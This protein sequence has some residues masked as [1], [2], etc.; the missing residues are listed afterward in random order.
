MSEIYLPCC[1]NFVDRS[2]VEIT[3]QDIR[4]GKTIKC[5]ECDSELYGEKLIWDEGRLILHENKGGI[6]G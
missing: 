6:K 4:R 2:K 3:D 1:D 5:P